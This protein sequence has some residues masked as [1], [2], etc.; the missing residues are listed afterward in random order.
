MPFVDTAMVAENIRALNDEQVRLSEIDR[1]KQEIEILRQ[2]NKDMLE[3]REKTKQECK[4]AEELQ[5]KLIKKLKI[6]QLK[7]KELEEKIEVA[8]EGGN[9]RL[10]T[11]E[12]LNFHYIDMIEDELNRVDLSI[13]SM[14]DLSRLIK[15]FNKQL[16]RTNDERDRRDHYVKNKLR[17]LGEDDSRVCTSQSTLI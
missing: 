4:Q 1:L 5:Q 16:Q 12:S 11:M 17:A 10:T 6:E 7:A 3:D 13:M 14:G 2:R 8:T 9:E 15:L